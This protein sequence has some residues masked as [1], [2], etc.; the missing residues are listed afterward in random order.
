V[1]TNVV[2]KIV[3]RS[4]NERGVAEPRC[5]SALLTGREILDKRQRDYWDLAEG[6]SG[7]QRP[8]ST[9]QSP[10]VNWQ[11]VGISRHHAGRPSVRR[12]H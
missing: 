1:A 5:V 7:G 8:R 10:L 6:S 3:A 2:P 12:S 4:P 11:S 9:V